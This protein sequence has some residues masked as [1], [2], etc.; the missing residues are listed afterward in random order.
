MAGEPLAR[1]G[2]FVDSGTWIAL[3]RERDRHHADAEAMLRAAIADRLR[4]LTTNLV[5][6]EVH[7]FILHRAGIRPAAVAIER[8]EQ[9]PHVQLVFPDADHH[10]AAHEW[11]ARF[12]DQRI[13]YTDAMS[14]AVMRASGCKAALTFDHDFA[15]AGF[16]TWPRA[17]G[18]R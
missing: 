12:A 5:L 10:R 9:S 8:I 7:R 15:V 17:S 4:L 14:F 18:K 11:L 13:T 6:A 16:E 1:V 3:F 2:V